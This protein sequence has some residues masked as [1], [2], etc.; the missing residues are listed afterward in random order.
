MPECMAL[1]SDA[2]MWPTVCRRCCGVRIVMASES[3]FAMLL[4][5]GVFRA[6]RTL[7]CDYV[8]RPLAGRGFWDVAVEWDSL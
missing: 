7:K 5:T 8:N 4:N 3:R 6:D 2:L 1:L